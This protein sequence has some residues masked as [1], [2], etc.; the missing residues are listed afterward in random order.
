[1]F[2][3]VLAGSAL[4]RSALHASV[5]SVPNQAPPPISAQGLMGFEFCFLAALFA[6]T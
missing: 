5:I 6:A 3:V 4:R 1:M 2:S